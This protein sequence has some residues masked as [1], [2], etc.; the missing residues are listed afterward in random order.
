MC[1]TNNLIEIK[2]H[3]IYTLTFVTCQPLTRSRWLPP[4]TDFTKINYDVIGLF[5]LKRTN[6]IWGCTWF[7]YQEQFWFSYCLMPQPRKVVSSQ[8]YTCSCEEIEALA[9][10]KTYTLF[11]FRV[12]NN[13]G[14]AGR[15]F[16]GCLQSSHG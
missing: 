3:N 1:Y 14:S 15:R 4:P 6:L 5:F 16:V 2:I 13:K 10:P 8:A 12:G 7:G 11:C 9:A